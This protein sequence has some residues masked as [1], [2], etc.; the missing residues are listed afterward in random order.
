MG[1]DDQVAIVST[2]GR[3][4]FLQQLTDNRVVLQT[5]DKSTRQCA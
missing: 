5:A 3:I 1:Q 4:G 2:S